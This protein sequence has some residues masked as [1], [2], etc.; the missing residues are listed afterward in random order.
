V[1]K[2]LY[3]PSLELRR[4]HNDLARRYKIVSGLSLTILK[5]D[6][7]MTFL[8]GTLQC[9]HAATP[10]N[11]IKEIALTGAELYFSR[12]VIN[13]WNQLPGSTDFS[14]LSSVMRNV[15]GIDLSRY[16]LSF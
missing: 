5:F 7:S 14:S 2:L 4:L 3:L 1:L 9:G 6:I 12:S 16:L 15:Y 11:F 8:S 10:S 13:V